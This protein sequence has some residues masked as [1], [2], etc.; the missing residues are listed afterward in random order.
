SSSRAGSSSPS[1]AQART[2]G[3]S[4]TASGSPSASAPPATTTR[5]AP[6]AT[7]STQREQL[8]PRLGAHSA[9]LDGFLERAVVALVL[10][11]VRLGERGDR[12]I[13]GAVR[14]EIRGDR[15]GVSGAGVPFGERRAADAGVDLE[16]VRLH[17]L[18]GRRA[19]LVPELTDVEVAFDAV[20]AVRTDPAEQDVCRCLRQA[21]ALD[22]PSAVAPA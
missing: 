7:P 18:D 20:E 4:S 10:V 6:P 21:L 11:G 17:H 15:D 3:R 8:R 12:T 9:R 19:L 2:S 13:E 14:A 16:R 5:F 1:S 22:D